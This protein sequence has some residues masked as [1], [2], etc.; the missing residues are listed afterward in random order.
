MPQGAKPTISRKPR[1]P[2][3]EDGRLNHKNEAQGISTLG[4]SNYTERRGSD[5]NLIVSFWRSFS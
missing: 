3:H 5:V 4:V 1:L 2:T